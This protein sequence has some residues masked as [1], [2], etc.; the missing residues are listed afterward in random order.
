[1]AVE[2]VGGS[3]Q[4]IGCVAWWDFLHGID[5]RR[6]RV[7]QPRPLQAA[8]R[9]SNV[10]VE[11]TSGRLSVSRVPSSGNAEPFCLSLWDSWRRRMED[12]TML[13][14]INAGFWVHCQSHIQGID[15]SRLELAD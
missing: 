8:E 5:L 1:L 4:A 14:G 15:E 7:R 2:I 6:T 11:S 13:V 10:S 9:E 12:E 3:P